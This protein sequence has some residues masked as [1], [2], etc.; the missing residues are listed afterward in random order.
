MRSLIKRVKRLM[1][2]TVACKSC[3]KSW[4][5]R[6]A[7]TMFLEEFSKLFQAALLVG[8]KIIVNMPAQ[9]IFAEIEIVFVAAADDVIERV[10]AEVSGLAELPAQGG[11][12]NSAPQRPD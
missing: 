7:A 5:E 10:E 4:F 11:V 8:S 3:H 1:R 2:L 9:I 12:F 6:L